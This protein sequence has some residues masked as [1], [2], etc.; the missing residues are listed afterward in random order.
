MAVVIARTIGTQSSPTPS[1]KNE[2]LP[3]TTLDE[4]INDTRQLN[5]FNYRNTYRSVKRMY[6]AQGDGC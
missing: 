3:I 1:T 4:I 6:V 5:Y 2:A